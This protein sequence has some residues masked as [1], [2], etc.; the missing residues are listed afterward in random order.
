MPTNTEALNLLDEV[1]NDLA[2]SAATKAQE[3]TE[4]DHA[5]AIKYVKRHAQHAYRVECHPRH[6]ECLCKGQFV[7][8]L[9]ISH[10][11]IAFGVALCV[12]DRHD[13]RIWV[14]DLIRER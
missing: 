4:D 1:I 3:A 12:H 14:S 13:W 11:L 10:G 9:L 5:E 2:H 6:Y 8:R 7:V